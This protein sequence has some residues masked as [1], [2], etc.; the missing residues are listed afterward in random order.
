[1]NRLRQFIRFFK[2]QYATESFE[3]AKI[4]PRHIRRYIAYLK[5]ERGNSPS[6]RNNKLSSLR[7]YYHFLECY[8]YIEENENPTLL[9][10]RARVHR[11]LPVYLTLEEAE[12]L[13][14]AAKTGRDPERDIALLRVMMQT[15]I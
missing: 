5:N 2:Q 11:R 7:S 10:M 3:P 6:T 15:G 4:L 13:L 8:E 14:D 12:L 1:L 9:I